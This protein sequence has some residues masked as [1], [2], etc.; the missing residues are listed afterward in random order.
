MAPST[1]EF[2]HYIYVNSSAGSLL[3]ILVNVGL[4]AAVVLI[5]C[6][7]FT[8]RIRKNGMDLTENAEERPSS[9]LIKVTIHKDNDT[10]ESNG[11][12]P[13]VIPTDAKINGETMDTEKN[14]PG[15]PPP[16]NGAVSGSLGSDATSA[17]MKNRVLPLIPKDQPVA[18]PPPE[19]DDHLYDSVNEIKERLAQQAVVAARSQLDTGTDRKSKDNSSKMISNSTRENEDE[20]GTLERINPL[21]DS[22]DDLKDQMSQQGL[23]SVISNPE[24]SEK[25]AECEEP[26]SARKI[27][28][29]S[30]YSVVHKKKPSVKKPPVENTATQENGPGDSALEGADLQEENNRGTDGNQTGHLPG[31]PGQKPPVCSTS[32]VT[33]ASVLD[34][35]K[36]RSIKYNPM[37]NTVVSISIQVDRDQPPPVP[38]RRFD[39]ESEMQQH[40]NEEE[41]ETAN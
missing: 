3:L 20:L 21:Y 10:L 26:Q 34:R 24:T 8:K 1:D 18:P 25:D 22:T 29:K 6:S 41:T 16:M 40:T 7:F 11:T 37:P 5:S 27:D 32:S 2:L 33:L 23:V 35:S 15:T 19:D 13:D 17:S 36:K 4:L 39:I 38:T 30:L 9:E 12:K 28:K 31:I 14:M